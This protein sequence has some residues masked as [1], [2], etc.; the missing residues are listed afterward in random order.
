MYENNINSKYIV[1]IQEIKDESKLSIKVIYLTIPV[2]GPG[3]I[4]FSIIDRHV[5]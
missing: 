2:S 5:G 1:N 3:L 4:P